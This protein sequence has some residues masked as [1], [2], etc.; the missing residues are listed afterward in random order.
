M[1]SNFI[2]FFIFVYLHNYPYLVYSP[3]NLY[4]PTNAPHSSILPEVGRT[5]ST[6]PFPFSPFPRPRQNWT[7]SEARPR[8]SRRHPITLNSVP[9][10]AL[11]SRTD[12]FSPGS[13][14]TG[15]DHANLSRFLTAGTIVAWCCSYNLRVFYNT[16]VFGRTWQLA[17]VV[18][19]SS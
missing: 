8:G 19:L 6:L 5:W 11:C 14:T 9:F 2:I 12:A 10:R 7:L 13:T 4:I 17:K 3:R 16:P 1:Y 15:H 18:S